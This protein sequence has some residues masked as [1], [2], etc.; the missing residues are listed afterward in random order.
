MKLPSTL[1]AAECDKG[2]ECLFSPLEDSRQRILVPLGGN[3]LFLQRL[4]GSEEIA[5][6]IDVIGSIAVSKTVRHGFES[7]VARQT[8]SWGPNFD[9][10]ASPLKRLE[11]SSNLGGPTTTIP[12]CSSWYE[13]A[14]LMRCNPSRTVRRFDP[15]SRSQ[16]TSSSSNWHRTHDFQSWKC[17]FESRRRY[18]GTLPRSTSGEVNWLSTSADGFDPRTGYQPQLLDV[19]S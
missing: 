8:I 6:V 9:G 12:R 17:G 1:Q 19:A 2:M 4:P 15:C 7:L 5:W 16:T 13:D 11:P 14:L 3:G 10:E 18:Q